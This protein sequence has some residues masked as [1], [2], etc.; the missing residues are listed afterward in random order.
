MKSYYYSLLQWTIRPTNIELQGRKS[1]HQCLIS[2]I[3]YMAYNINIFGL[4]I[5]STMADR[6]FL[7]FGKY[8]TYAKSMHYDQSV[9]MLII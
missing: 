9:T 7:L 1:E 4:H 5:F 8:N 6:K 3:C 2:N